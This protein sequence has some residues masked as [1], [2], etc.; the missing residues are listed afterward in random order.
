MPNTTSIAGDEL[1]AWTDAIL[2]ATGASPEAA[3]ATAAALVDASLRGLDSHGVVFLAFYL[4]RLAKGTTRGDAHPE[5]VADREAYA[6]VDGHDALGAYVAR[7]AMDLCCDKAKRAGAAAVAV[8]GSTH[9]GAASCYAEQAAG[10]GCVGIALSNSDPGMAPLGA[11]APVLGTNPLAIA[12]P[13][14]PDLPGPSLD[15]ATSVVAQGKLILAQ[16]AGE[17]IP[18]GWAIGPDGRE[19]T[20]PAAGL[21]NSVLPMAGHKGF[22][23]ALMLDVLTGC[24]SGAD[25]SPHIVGDPETDRPQNAGH[26]FIAIDLDGNRDRDA[27]SESLRDLAG[28]VHDAARAD[29]AD[30]FLLPGEPEA[31]TAE[32]R[33]RDGVELTESTTELLRSLGDRYGVEFPA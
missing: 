23:L 17:E 29:W 14:A 6:L 19:T 4:P 22:G 24:L 1:R 12:A 3:E 9:F 13:G 15:I 18:P 33:R 8:R 5:V 21:E 2:R 25:T 16:R 26:L 32:R 28:Q 30:P 7:F 27:Y 10:R 11:L 20:D 31:R